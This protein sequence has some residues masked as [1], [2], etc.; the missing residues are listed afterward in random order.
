MARAVVVMGV[1]GSGK[2]AVAAGLAGHLG[3]RAA[4][5][6]ALH[7]PEAVAR[8][9]AG[10][11]L[12]DA[13]RLPWLDRVGAA[14]AA[15]A[16]DAGVVMACSA[17]RRAYRDRLRAAC[18]GLRFVFLDGSREVIAGRMALRRDH[19]MPVSLLDS[20]LMTLER[21]GAEEADVTRVDIEQPLP[22]VVQ[23]AADALTGSRP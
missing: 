6:D 11:A 2:S 19:Y 10:H 13:D 17:L 18:P 21:P 14:L 1:C 15:G 4:D 22:A 8:M 9:R 23:R 5:A 16:R 20:Q 7:A 12:T 3:W